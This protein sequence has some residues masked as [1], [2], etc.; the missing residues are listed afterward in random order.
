MCTQSTP[1][2]PHTHVP[3]HVYTTPHTQVPK[4]VYTTPTH[5]L[6]PHTCT[7]ACVHYPP[8]PHTHTCVIH[9]RT[10]HGGQ[11]VAYV[12]NDLL[13]PLCFEHGYLFLYG[14]TECPSLGKGNGWR[15]TLQFYQR[16]EPFDITASSR[17]YYTC[18]RNGQS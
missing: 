10:F 14:R 7:R 5:T 17:V 12:R 11:S 4:H 8:P 3:E 6:P 13:Q 15:T 1:H 18:G 2:P 16:G 9:A